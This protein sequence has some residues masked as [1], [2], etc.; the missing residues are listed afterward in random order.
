MLKRTSFQNYVE[1]FA[2]NI[3]GFFLRLFSLKV[4]LKIGKFI[5]IF[6]YHCIPIRRKHIF[7]MLLISFPEKSKKEV[8]FIAKN[9][10]RN[11]MMTVVEVIFFPK[12]SDEEISK[13]L[14]CKNEFL[15]EKSYAAGRGTILMSAHFGNWELTA[16]AFSKKYPM[17]VVVAKQSNRLVDNM[18]N[19]IRT[20]N[21]FCTISRDGMIFKSVLRALKEN[22]IVAILSDQ[23]A[24]KQ[25]IFIP[26][27]GRLASTPKGAALFALRAKCQLIIALGVRQNDG[28][29]KIEFTEVPMPNTGTEEKKLKI[30]NAFYSKKLEEVVRKNPEQWFWFHRKWNTRP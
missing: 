18:L 23:D 11:F 26:F 21:G 12:M 22:K 6:V 16:L 29:M 15:V 13:L 25:G 24:G 19:K 10:Y 2:I 1:F 14:I 8:K 4:S 28:V 27:L 20:L 17:S 7:N 30:V 5:A 9:V 3:L